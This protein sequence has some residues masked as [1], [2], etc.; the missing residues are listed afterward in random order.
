MKISNVNIVDPGSVRTITDAPQTG[1]LC[2]DVIGINQRNHEPI[3][4]CFVGSWLKKCGL[5]VKIIYPRSDNLSI[6]E[7]LDG[8]PQIVA[9]SCLTYNYPLAR[10]IA[11]R[12]KKSRPEIITVI[13]GYHATCVPQEVSA[14]KCDYNSDYVFDFVVAQEADWTLGDLAEFLN[15][16]RK[17]E[18]VRGLV[19][20][21]GEVWLDNFHRFDPNLNPLPL[22]TKE[23]ML[24]RQRFG[25]YY[26]APSQQRAVSL[27]VWSRGCP[28]NCCFCISKKMFPHCKGEQAVRYRDIG[29]IINEVRFC[30]KEYGTNYGFCVDLNFYGGSGNVERIKELCREL[31]K[32]GLKWYGMSRLDADPKIYEIMKEGGCSTIGFGVES[33]TNVIK[34]GAKMT[35]EQWRKKAKDTASLLRS[36]GI[37]TKFYYILGGPNEN[38]ENIHAEG[39]AILGVDCDEIR[40]S[41]FMPSPGTPIFKQLK[42][43]GGLEKDGEDLSLFSTDFPI[44]KIAGADANELQKLRMDIYRRF[45]SPARY[46]PHAA[47]MISRFSHLEKSFLEFNEI[48]RQSLGKGWQ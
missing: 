29:N 43:T 4:A 22:R 30:K 40:M 16:D 1:G 41:W 13:G 42:K 9:F 20:K 45:Y 19:Y 18:E 7:V 2:Q 44:I 32:T 31:S 6:A 25:L 48:L 27:F 37:M 11:V 14:E 28:Y 21:Q 39:D 35:P 3:G 23:M 34:S 5:G 47:E 15:G 8:D 17:K 24:G 46:Q 36:L 10:K 12:I 26:P 38:V 33:L